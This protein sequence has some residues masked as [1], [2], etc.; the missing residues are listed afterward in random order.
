MSRSLLIGK[1]IFVGFVWGLVTFP[2]T[3]TAQ[4]SR[5]ARETAEYVMK[6]FSRKVGA[7]SVETLAL[8]IERLSLRYGDEVIPVIRKGGPTVLRALEEAGEE[9]PRL[10]KFS[11]RYGDQAIWVISRTKGAAIFLRYGDDAGRA[12]IKHGEIVEDVIESYGQPAAK[13][14]AE[15]SGQQARRLVSMHKNGELARIGRAKELLETITQKS[16][17]GWADKVMDFIWRNKGALTVGTLLVAFLTN[18]EP[19][20][21]GTVKLGEHTVGKI[22]EGVARNTNWTVIIILGILAIVGLIIFR[23]YR[24]NHLLRKSSKNPDVAVQNL[25]KSQNP[26]L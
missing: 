12:M 9:A 7:G 21:N 4:F 18:P 2:Q 14:M 24:Q 3:L 6:K 5:A 26:T 13:A 22:S 20:I 11:L 8:R 15:L 23:I 16:E 25:P 1:F 17:P 10:V 19:F